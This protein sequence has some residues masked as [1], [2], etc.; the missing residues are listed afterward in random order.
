M[1]TPKPQIFRSGLVSCIKGVGEG[2]PV[3]LCRSLETERTVTFVVSYLQV[4]LFTN[5][6]NPLYYLAIVSAIKSPQLKC[7]LLLSKEG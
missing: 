6:L 2:E 3:E 5:L 7:N 1:F 4:S